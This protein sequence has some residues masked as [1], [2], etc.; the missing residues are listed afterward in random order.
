ML[1]AP[2]LFQA[3]YLPEFDLFG[4]ACTLFAG[5][6]LYAESPPSRRRWCGI[7]AALA[8]TLLLKEASALVQFAFLGALG[9]HIL[10]G[11]G[12]REHLKR[13]IGITL[14]CVVFWSSLVWQMLMAPSTDVG[15]LTILE[16]LPLLEHN[17]T[18]LVYLASPAAAVVLGAWAM[19]R[20][21]LLPQWL[22]PVLGLLG[23]L[24]APIAVF[25][26]HYEAVYYAPR[27]Y[28][29]GL[30]VLLVGGLLLS[31]TNRS[32]IPP[33]VL[34]TIF[35]TLGVLSLVGLVA[36]S[37][38]EDMAS[39]IFVALTPLLYAAAMEGIRRTWIRMGR[40]PSKSMGK[41]AG[42]L[43][44]GALALTLAMYP[45]ASTINYCMDWRARHTVDLAAKK[46]LANTHL[47]DTLI[48]FNHYV[49]WLD[50]LGLEAAG[51]ERPGP[52]TD[53]LQVPAWL[54][55]EDYKR[56]IWI[57]PSP[58]SDLLATLNT[59]RKALLYWLAPRSSMSQQANDILIGDLSWTRK[60]YGLFSQVAD[61][62][63][64]IEGIAYRPHNRPEDHRMSMYRK[65]PSPLEQMASELG[66]KNWSTNRDFIQL[67]LLITEL[68]RRLLTGIPLVEHY[69]YEGALTHF[70]R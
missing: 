10:L 5:A 38:R 63:F 27:A 50:P 48:L 20:I 61:G 69:N 67:P 25:Y 13:I 2:A 66:E 60:D 62:T 3:W 11:G 9:L 26:S 52:E 18:Q 1:G 68:P 54:P 7:G 58:P 32:G 44:T 43:S 35:S 34:L 65:G 24:I 30:S 19:G 59:G 15:R 33:I 31:P 12:S 64:H 47:D 17:T 53:F 37:A 28:G 6:W 55:P 40:L 57:H 8:A 45:L 39:R 16:K 42:R 23:L 49:E 46:T 36:P 29:L 41:R 51:A 70:P 22:P 14:I 4:A 21:K 56:G